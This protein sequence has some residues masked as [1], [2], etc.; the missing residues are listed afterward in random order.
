MRLA[1]TAAIDHPTVAALA[2]AVAAKVGGGRGAAPAGPIPSLPTPASTSS[3]TAIAIVGMASRHPPLAG[4]VVTTTVSLPSFWRAL[5][6]GRDVAARVPASRW[7]AD[8]HY[9]AAP[10]PH[11]AYVN[12]GGWLPSVAEFDCAA[13]RLGGAEA[14]AVDPQARLVLE[15]VR[16]R[17]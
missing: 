10:R 1:A 8:A 9:A 5:A 6:S 13:F 14:A 16:V 15:C 3:T 7:D 2:A 11:K 12:A 17:E 4:D